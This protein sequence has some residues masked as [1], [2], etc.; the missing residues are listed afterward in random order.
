MVTVSFQTIKMQTKTYVY[1][2]AGAYRG[3]KRTSDPLELEAQAVVSYS[4]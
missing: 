2:C 4:M 1:I 3:Q